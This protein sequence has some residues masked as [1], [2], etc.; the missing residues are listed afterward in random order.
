LD[1]EAANAEQIRS[2]CAR[3]FPN[4][5]SVAKQKV[6]TQIEPSHIVWL[7]LNIIGKEVLHGQ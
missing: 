3:Y 7:D 6:H 5:V 2:M 1:G 4:Q